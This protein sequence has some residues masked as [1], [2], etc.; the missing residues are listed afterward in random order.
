M[1]LSFG[2]KSMEMLEGS[3]GNK[4]EID[5][6]VRKFPLSILGEIENVRRFRFVEVKNIGLLRPL[7][8]NLAPIV[9]RNHLKIPFVWPGLAI[10]KIEAEKILY[11]N[12]WIKN[13]YDQLNP[14]K[15]FELAEILFGKEAAQEFIELKKLIKKRGV[16]F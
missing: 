14:L 2:E 3:I 12:F 8:L 13:D 15:V 16:R 6:V 4:A 1:F 7:D 10:Q 5:F 9:T 11:D